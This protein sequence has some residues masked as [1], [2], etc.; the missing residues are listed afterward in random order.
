MITPRAA[1]VAL[2]CALGAGALLAAC[3]AD[4][5]PDPAPTTT[6]TT[7]TAT[8]ASSTPPASPTSSGPAFDCTTVRSA[9]DALDDAYAA[10]LDALGVERG[11]PQAQSVFTVVTTTEGPEYY[12]AVLAAAPPGSLPDA[13]VVLDYYT[14]LAT[15]VGALDPGTTDDLPGAMTAIDDAAVVVNPDP[16]AATAVVAAQERLQ[17]AVERDCAGSTPTQS[18]TQTATQSPSPSGTVTT[19]PDAAG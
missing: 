4:G 10:E 17:A 1:P 16:A 13:Q 7:P 2:W 14:R 9:Q 19:S 5:S 12:A 8:A 11:D 15:Q 3:G 6:T 18:A